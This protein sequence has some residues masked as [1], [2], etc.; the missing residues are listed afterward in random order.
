[1]GFDLF[2]GHEEIMQLVVELFTGA[3]FYKS[4]L[5]P[6]IGAVIER[7]EHLH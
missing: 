4:T 6:V 5:Y 3:Y 2:L 1:V 7:L